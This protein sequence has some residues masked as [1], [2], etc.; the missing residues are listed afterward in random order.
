MNS[1][2]KPK[3]KPKKHA[4]VDLPVD[5]PDV[6]PSIVIDQFWTFD[7]YNQRSIPVPKHAEGLKC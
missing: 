5:L 4:A 7:A 3:R 1:S 2:K 6:D